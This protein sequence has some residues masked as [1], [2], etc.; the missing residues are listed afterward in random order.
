VSLSVKEDRQCLLNEDENKVVKPEEDVWHSASPQFDVSSESFDV[1][2]I[3]LNGDDGRTLEYSTVLSP[4]EVDRADRFHFDVHRARYVNCRGSLRHI[5]GRYLHRAPAQIRFRYEVNGKP[6]LVDEQNEQQLR[7][8]VS[9]CSDLALLAVTCKRAVGVDVE[10]LRDQ[11]DC[12]ELAKRYFS[13][14]EYEDLLT[15]NGEARQRAFFACWTR[16]EAF[17]KACGAGLSYPLSEFSV[18]V[19]PDRPA[20]IEE[21]RPGSHAALNWSLVSLEPEEKYVGAVVFEGPSCTVKRWHW[22]HS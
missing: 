4:D 20:R 13:Q 21:A 18:S 3:P 19:L 2:R 14:R 15:L 1:W 22:K 10:L 12:L 8:N 11:P 6:E 9:H 17:V 5:L 16:K 7:F